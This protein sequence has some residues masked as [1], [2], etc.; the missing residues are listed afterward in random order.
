MIEHRHCLDL[1]KHSG[2]FTLHLLKTNW[3]KFDYLLLHI[4]MC[5]F[6]KNIQNRLGH[7]FI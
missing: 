6:V 7:V 3:K 2:A 1:G 5:F 4:N